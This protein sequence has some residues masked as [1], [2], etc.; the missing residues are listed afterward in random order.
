[1]IM[2][3]ETICPIFGGE[4]SLGGEFSAYLAAKS[5]SGENST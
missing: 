4:F 2:E 1:M 5:P 3:I